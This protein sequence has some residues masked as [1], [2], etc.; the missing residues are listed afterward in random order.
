MSREYRSSIHECGVL[1]LV[2]L[3]DRRSSC[4]CDLR[5]DVSSEY[6][7]YLHLACKELYDDDPYKYICYYYNIKSATS[8]QRVW[9]IYFLNK[10]ILNEAAT[11]CKLRY[12]KEAE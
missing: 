5:L 9:R 2:D 6:R 3:R 8:C 4:F 12:S 10:E 1:T 11:Y 7:S